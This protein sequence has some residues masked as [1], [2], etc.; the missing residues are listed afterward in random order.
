VEQASPAALLY[1]LAVA[2]HPYKP[3]ARLSEVCIL[4]LHDVV[5]SAVVYDLQRIEVLRKFI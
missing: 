5:M 1:C 4:L 2:D 3:V